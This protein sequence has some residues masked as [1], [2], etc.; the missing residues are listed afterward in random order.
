VSYVPFESGHIDSTS[1]GNAAGRGG[2]G[3]QANVQVVT[4]RHSGYIPR[5]IVGTRGTDKAQRL[6]SRQHHMERY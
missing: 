2:H 5:D 3:A 1:N 4:D 6:Q